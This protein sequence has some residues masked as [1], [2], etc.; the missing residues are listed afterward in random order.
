M[1][2]KYLSNIWR[3]IEVPLVI[4]KLELKLKWRKYCVLSANGNDHV[5]HND[6][7]KNIIFTIKDLKV[8]VPIVTL[9]ARDNQKLPKPLNKAFADQVIEMNIKRKVRSKI[10][11]KNIDIFL[12]QILLESIDY[13][14]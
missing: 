1:S 13:L 3:S 8:Y 11:Q 10:R 12:N 4:C 14:F 6:Q 2:S 7:V 9:S 5:N